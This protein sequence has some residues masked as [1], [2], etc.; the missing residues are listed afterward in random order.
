MKQR[1]A[2]LNIPGHTTLHLPITTGTERETG[3]NID[4]LRSQTG[5][6]TLDSG[7]GNTGSCQSA[8]TFVDGENGVLL[9][10]GYPIDQLAEL[11]F[12]EV[13]Y[14]VFVG[15]LPNQAQLRYFKKLL[16]AE[17]CYPSNLFPHYTQGLHPML[18]FSQG[19]SNLTAT[20]PK[21]GS[22]LG[23]LAHVVAKA[24]S[25]VGW[26]KRA[27][28]DGSIDLPTF[29]PGSYASRLAQAL[30]APHNRSYTPK[31]A[32]DNALN[33]LLILHADHEQNCSTSTVRMVGSSRA[34]LCASLA[35]GIMA[36][37][38]DL[39]GGANQKVIEML[40]T[41]HADGDDYGKYVGLAKDKSSGFRLMGFG[42]RVYKN[43]DPRSRILKGAAD[44]VLAALGV[45]D[46][47]LAIARA[48]TS[49]AG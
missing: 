11:S 33:L 46:P 36:L 45:D 10:R 24:L 9:Y 27:T 37:W 43:F 17:Y 41:I 29:Q 16:L 49:G 20:T 38:G 26:I 25:L 32:T 3:L 35:A 47:L 40:R 39:H 8:I 5:A 44:A 42:H 18:L 14:L 19:I 28:D 21:C 7:Y 4:R 22:D 31:R 30:F 13:M 23:L 48:G 2:T 34:H 1:F 15:E 6:I 12:E